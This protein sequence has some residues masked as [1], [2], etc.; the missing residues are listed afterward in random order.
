MLAKMCFVTVTAEMLADLHARF[1]PY[2]RPKV[3]V[4]Q[5]PPHLLPTPKLKT[6]TVVEDTCTHIKSLQP[7]QSSL[8]VLL[9]S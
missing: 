3:E 2:F 8:L 1:S 7:S 4:S 5:F 6:D 9:L